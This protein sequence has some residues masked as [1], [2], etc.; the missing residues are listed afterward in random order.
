MKQKETQRLRCARNLEKA[1][2]HQPLPPPFHILTAQYSSAHRLVSLVLSALTD[3]VL[4]HKVNQMVLIDY[5]WTK[6]EIYLYICMCTY[7]RIFMYTYMFYIYICVC[8]CVKSFFFF[9]VCQRE[10]KYFKMNRSTKRFI[11]I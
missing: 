3:P 10:K 4:N 2:P 1:L 8:V 6:R 5:E 9:F 7:V 11:C